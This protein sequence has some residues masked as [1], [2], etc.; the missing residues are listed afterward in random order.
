MKK[1]IFCVVV[2]FLGLAGC[3][4]NR[5]SFPSA[6][7]PILD[8]RVAEL[9]SRE[10]GVCIAGRVKMSD[11][12]P[13]HSGKDVKVNFLQ[14]VDAPLWIYDGG[15]FMMDRTFQPQPSPYQ[16]P[17]K[18][19][20]RAF[21]YDSIDAS[22]AP[23]QGQITYLEFVMHKTPVEKLAS[24]TGTVINEQ[25]EPID[26]ARISLSF[27]FAYNVTNDE[28]R[29]SI[30]TE[31]DGQYSFEDLSITEHHIL[32]SASGYA[33]FS[34]NVTPLAGR[35]TTKN[36]KIYRNHSIIIDYVYQA[37]GS[38][39]FTGG[40]LQSG[41]LEWGN[42]H[43]GLDFS[44]GRVEE[45]EHGSERDIEMRQYQGLPKFQIFY[46]DS[47]IDNGF[48]DAGTVAFDSVAEAAEKNYDRN[49]KP[50]VAGHVYIVK[51]YEG[52]YAKFIVKEIGIQ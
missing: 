22:L 52:N 6:L 13:I 41:T 50:C 26:S 48:Y 28:P 5:N 24:I 46:V 8:Q 31:Q 23:L 19:A 33:S 12:T 37:D 45:Y 11:G 51:T 20:L 32:V 27:S 3:T 7:R 15:W 29:I 36:L 4:L 38:R 1:I 17:A 14:N 21:G 49:A 40:K 35:T 44:D 18:L 42:G 9:A 34:T 43:Q 10:D 16:R 39:S 25:N 47:K 2:C 30:N